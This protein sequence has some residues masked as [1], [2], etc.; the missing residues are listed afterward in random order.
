MRVSLVT[1]TA[2][3]PNFLLECALSV[4]GQVIPCHQWINKPLYYYRIHDD[5]ITGRKRERQKEN[6]RRAVN[7]ILTTP[8]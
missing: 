5:S 8:R 6:F 1:T 7:A 4:A 3:R 2:Q